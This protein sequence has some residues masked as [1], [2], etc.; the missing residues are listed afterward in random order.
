MFAPHRT[1]DHAQHDRVTAMRAELVE[2]SAADDGTGD[3]ESV[4]LAMKPETRPRTTRD[5]IGMELAPA[6][7]RRRPRQRGTN[8][9]S[10]IRR[11]F[12]GRRPSASKL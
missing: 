4:P 10:G 8:A 1:G 5:G 11:P 3:A 12:L 7:E 6:G 9:S 2:E